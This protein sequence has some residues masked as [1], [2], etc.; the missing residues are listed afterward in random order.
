MSCI[1]HKYHAKASFG[2]PQHLL[3][4]PK[5]K[6]SILYAPS[7]P[8]IP[9]AGFS[10]RLCCIFFFQNPLLIIHPPKHWIAKCKSLLS[11]LAS[12]T[13]ERFYLK[14]HICI[15]LSLMSFSC[16]LP[17]THTPPPHPFKSAFYQP[18]GLFFPH[19]NFSDATLQ[20]F[21]HSYLM[22]IIRN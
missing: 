3:Q 1:K 9:G 17:P 20:K 2:T 12:R 14:D 13:E 4:K 11:S 15:C 8:L 18:C 19:Q 6:R 10:H 16:L 22:R 5:K 7:G 21:F